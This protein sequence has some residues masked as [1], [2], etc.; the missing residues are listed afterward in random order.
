M[1]FWA[2]EWLSAVA[3]GR[4]RRRD[5]AWPSS[6]RGAS[7]DEEVPSGGVS[8]PPLAAS[9]ANPPIDCIPKRRTDRNAARLLSRQISTSITP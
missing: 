5:E 9:F 6:M 1:Q 8:S 3:T 7:E 4:L 2:A